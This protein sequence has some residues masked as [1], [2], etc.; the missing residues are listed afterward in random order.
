MVP[1]GSGHWY[2]STTVA[3]SEGSTWAAKIAGTSLPSS[4]RMLN[5]VM[6][7]AERRRGDMTCLGKEEGERPSL[8]TIRLSPKCCNLRA[9]TVGL[10]F[11]LELAAV[12]VKCC[13]MLPDA[14]AT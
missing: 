11:R 2:R 14:A 4:R 6:R 9:G 5:P 10:Q 3:G 13:R 12:A 8:S 7:P 1:G